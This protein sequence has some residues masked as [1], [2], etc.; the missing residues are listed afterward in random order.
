M[1]KLL[2]KIRQSLSADRFPFDDLPEVCKMHVF[3][4]LDVSDRV[5]A[6]RVCH[7]WNALVRRPF[8]WANVDVTEAV[9]ES[10][11]RRRPTRHLSER[12]SELRSRTMK[13]LSYVCTIDPVVRRL[14]L[15]G[16][17]VDGEFHDK[18]QQFANDSKL[19][20]LREVVIDWTRSTKLPQSDDTADGRS[21]SNSLEDNNNSAAVAEDTSHRRRQRQRMFARFFE[22]LARSAP[23]LRSVA[24]PFDW[25]PKSI[26]ALIGLSQL[27]TAVLDRYSDVVQTLDVTMLQRVLASMT[28]LRRLDFEVWS[29]C[30]S[31][32]LTFYRLFSDSLETLDMSRCR[33][34]ALAEVCLPHLLR[35]HISCEPWSGPLVVVARSGGVLPG[36]T[37]PPCLYQVLIRGAPSLVELNGHRLQPGW[38]SS[39]YDELERVLEAVC[40]CELHQPCDGAA[41]ADAFCF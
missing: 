16:D 21:S 13:Y 12:E 14:V 33:G 40:P 36:Q 34:V 11:R 22:V 17:I 32:G 27:E 31:G 18:I 3:S 25:S 1:G 23:H 8:L 20:E 38:Q 5:N 24:M 2:S 19:A 39:T 30:A 10:S 29:A 41:A 35:L 7:E 6:S 28:S 37:T 9:R 15:V 26:E 4:Y